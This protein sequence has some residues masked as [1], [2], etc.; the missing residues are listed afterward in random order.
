MIVA[1]H[2]GLESSSGDRRQLDQV[3]SPIFDYLS[4]SMRERRCIVPT[5]AYA[6]PHTQDLLRALFHLT[7]ADAKLCG[8]G[9]VRGLPANSTVVALLQFE[10]TTLLPAPRHSRGIATLAPR[11]RTR[12]SA[13]CDT[14]MTRLAGHVFS[15]MNVVQSILSGVMT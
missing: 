11:L 3:G 13:L 2:V 5:S 12:G 9:A 10:R 8:R 1:H 14:R 4:E 6:V 7:V 15:L